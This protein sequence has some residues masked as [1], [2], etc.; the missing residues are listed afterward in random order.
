[1]LVFGDEDVVRS[2]DSVLADCRHVLGDLVYADARQD[3]DKGCLTGTCEEVLDAILGWAAQA[4]P[5]SPREGSVVGGIAYTADSRVLWVCGLSGSGKSTIARSVA[6][7]LKDL[8]R[9]GS[10]YAFD[11]ARQAALNPTT[12]LPTV[13]RDLADHDPLRKKRLVDTIR[14]E[15]ALRKTTDIVEQFKTFIAE[16]SSE[17]AAVGDTV[18]VIDAFDESSKIGGRETLLSML[19]SSAHEIPEGLKF[20]VMS[21]S[22][23][24]VQEATVA[25]APAGAVNLFVLDNAPQDSTSRDIARFVHHTLGKVRQLRRHGESIERLAVMA[26]HSFQWASTACR[27]ILAVDDGYGGSYR[28]RLTRILDGKGGL[29]Y[30]YTLVLDRS[31][32]MAHPHT[33]SQLQT[34]TGLMICAIEPLPL[35]A[36]ITLASSC[37][38]PS[39]DDIDDFREMA[40][41]LGSLLSGVHSLL[42][43]VKPLH[44]SFSDF[45]RNGERSGRYSIDMMEIKR[46]ITRRCMEVMVQ[47]GL[48]FNICHFPTS[49]RR[50]SEVDDLDNA[51]QVH[52]SPLLLYSCRYWTQHIS[53]IYDENPDRIGSLLLRLLRDHLLHWLEV[54]SLLGSNPYTALAEISH[55][56]SGSETCPRR[57]LLTAGPY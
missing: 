39:E 32:A 17:L 34:F 30:L 29:D 8:G 26:E 11:E 48:K 36:L 21:R 5:P 43:V 19:T 6:T 54:M 7:R 23:P 27:F 57:Q 24:D 2:S 45:L 33:L 52:I 20:I 4:T 46:V 1:M 41:Q 35:Q 38:E 15:L 18:V 3:V 25:S 55:T 50:N 28:D 37:N 44:T 40:G 42:T 10:Y 13:A 22:E 16:P 14:N 49:F 47:G 12:L 51:I 53:D 9:L 31:F 56:V